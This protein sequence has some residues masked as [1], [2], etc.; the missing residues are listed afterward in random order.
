MEYVSPYVKRYFYLTEI[1]QLVRLRK[2]S[3]KAT[4]KSSF[5]RVLKDSIKKLRINPS[6][7]I[8]MLG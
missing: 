1:F 8:F 3:S 2:Q 7:L 4:V 5:K 6:M